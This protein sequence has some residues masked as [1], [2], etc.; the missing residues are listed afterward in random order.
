MERHRTHVMI[1]SLCVALA[2]CAGSRPGA[3]DAPGIARNAPAPE[4]SLAARAYQCEDGTRL[5]A[6]R[7]GPDRLY[8]FFP[9][10]NVEL[11]RARSASGARYTGPEGVEFW[12]RGRQAR[13]VTQDGDTLGCEEDRL[14]SLIEDARLRGVDFWALGNEPGWRLEMGPRRV[15]LET[16]YGKRTLHFPAQAVDAALA[17]EAPVALT[18]EAGGLSLPLRLEPGPCR[19][20]M[21]GQPFEWQVEIGLEGQTLRGCG[22]A[23]H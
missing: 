8:L 4:A 19:D 15:T 1:F 22:V 17:R 3:G 12:S 10:S 16:D 2:G 9:A 11:R 21:S 20:D 18:L 6:E 14:G 23:L 5:V 7:E 13:V